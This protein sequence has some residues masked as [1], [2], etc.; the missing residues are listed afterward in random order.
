MRRKI[1]LLLVSLAAATTGPSAFAQDAKLGAPIEECIRSNAAK[2]ESA[3]DDLSRATSFLV[4]NVCAEPVAAENARKMKVSAER[5]AK[6]LQAWC[7]DQKKS[8]TQPPGSASLSYMCAASGATH[9][10]FSGIDQYDGDDDDSL[11]FVG[12]SPPAAIGLASRLLL[13]LRLSHS[14]TGQPR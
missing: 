4:S 13:D 10:G 12:T 8:N 1:T 3:I 5:R 7:D 2:V 9:I 11:S 6:Q 14:K